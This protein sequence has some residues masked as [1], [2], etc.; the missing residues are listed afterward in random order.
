M[1]AIIIMLGLLAVMGIV[2]RHEFRYA[3]QQEVAGIVRPALDKKELKMNKVKVRFTPS[4]EKVPENI[5]TLDDPRIFLFVDV[6]FCD[7]HVGYH[8]T[9]D[10]FKDSNTGHS[11]TATAWIE[12]EVDG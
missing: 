12:I 10:V 8:L 3:Q 2:G 6:G 4:E 1:R 5:P 11:Y 9:K 7:L